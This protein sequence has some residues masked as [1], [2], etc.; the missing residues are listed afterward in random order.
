MEF[1]YR[2]IVLPSPRHPAPGGPGPF[3]TRVDPLNLPVRALAAVL[4]ALLLGASAVLAQSPSVPPP[5]GGSAPVAP[6]ASVVP[7]APRVRAL[8]DKEVFGF[9][10]YWNLGEAAQS[11][12]LDKL[13]TLAWFG[14]EAGPKG[15]LI[16]KTS[17]GAVPN[18]YRG[19]TDPTWKALMAK[20][21]AK[22]VRVVLTVERM[23]WDPGSR[24]R[25]VK[26][27]QSPKAR[28]RLAKDIA[29]EL[30]ATGAD[31]VNLDFE[32]MPA[33]VR[34]DFTLFV[35]ELRSVLDATRPGMQITFDITASVPTYDIAAL[36]ADDAADAVFLMAYDFIGYGAATAASISPL[37]DPVTHFDIQTTMADLVAVADPQHIILGLPWYGR[38]WTTKTPEANSPTRSGNQ[39]MK[40]ATPNY[41]QALAIARL[42]GRKYDPVAA[43]AWSA[44]VVKACPSCAE[45][46]RQVWYDDVE[47]FAT[48]IRF[49][50]DQGLRGIG[51]WALGNTGSLPGM[52]TVI[53]LTIG[54]RV[55]D[56]PPTG[57]ASVAPGS[58]GRQ[59]G[60][61][62]ADGP[63]TVDLRGTDEQ[64]GSG[65][66]FVRLSNDPEVDVAG[67]L[68]TGSTW[69]GTD[70][71][72]WSVADG[73]VVVPPATP[74]PKP[75]K[76]PKTTPG[77]TQSAAPVII[78]GTRSIHVQWRDVAGNWS[79][80]IVVDVWY[81]PKGSVKAAPSASPG[82]SPGASVPAG[83]PGASDGS[84]G[85][86]AP[87]SEA[88]TSTPAPT[89]TRT[90]APP[91]TKAPAP[92]PTRTASPP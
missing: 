6:L 47:G 90:P 82:T 53:D 28:T 26:L 11:V 67:M 14:V 71:V 64:G 15:R 48:K 44:Y 21:Q 9:L 74:R 19:W 33:E 2:R 75:T 1:G 88:P 72:A 17:A 66:A 10:P 68:A 57:A 73:Q 41:E 63:V 60:L 18:G 91:P 7:G 4:L 55:D 36:T 59:D 23:S 30:Q 86:E 61:P 39:L 62:I 35:R 38:A 12:D 87:G 69:P 51:M 83:S 78:A 81:A 34:D 13:T 29:A 56:I 27:L 76:K 84:G 65:V 52:W 32:P 92:A 85:A 77:P 70:S 45:A 42:N 79:T 3:R 37:V 54:D 58:L 31:G 20:A 43:T 16:R 25:T 40:P 24:A 50:I 80:P 5:V 8:A 49:A 22:G 89:P 46:W